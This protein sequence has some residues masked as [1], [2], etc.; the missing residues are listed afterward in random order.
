MQLITS[1]QFSNS[2]CPCFRMD[3]WSRPRY[4]RT[5]KHRCCRWDVGHLEL[6]RRGD[7]SHRQPH[8]VVAASTRIC[9]ENDLRFEPFG[10]WRRCCFLR[11]G[12][13]RD[14]WTLQSPDN[15]C[16]SKGCWEICMRTE[17]PKQSHCVPDRCW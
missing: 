1:H 5:T 14:Y 17:Q 4:R 12:Q 2:S 10:D 15:G 7:D 13:I 6:Q 8:L 3:G 11:L 16:R 9:S